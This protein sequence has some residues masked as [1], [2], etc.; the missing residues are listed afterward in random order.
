MPVPWLVGNENTVCLYTKQVLCFK[1]RET[2]IGI[3]FFF[4]QS[5]GQS[6][7]HAAILISHMQL[8]LSCGNVS[9]SWLCFCAAGLKT[10]CLSLPRGNGHPF[11]KSSGSLASA[12]LNSSVVRTS[13][14]NKTPKPLQN[15]SLIL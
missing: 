3:F 1:V 12:L 8:E 13:K 5:F 6:T 7:S 4:F 14:T 2:M 9:S 11:R 15:Q 10:S